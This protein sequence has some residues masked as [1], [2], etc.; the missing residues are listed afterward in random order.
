M[1]AGACAENPSGGYH[2]CLAHRFPSSPSPS[3][4]D[5]LGEAFGDYQA[6]L[7][8]DSYTRVSDCPTTGDRTTARYLI[9]VAGTMTANLVAGSSAAIIVVASRA[10]MVMPAPV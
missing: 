1:S 10:T 6:A 9:D 7:T 2:L 8:W 4:S 5:R 3:S